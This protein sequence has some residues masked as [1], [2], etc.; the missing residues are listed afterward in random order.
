MK[1]SFVIPIY[2]HFRLINDLLIEINR[3][4]KPDEIIVVDDCST[5][6]ETHDGLSWWEQNAD[7]KVIRPIENLGFLKASNYGVSK[8]TGDIICL[9]SSDVKIED[10]L[11]K[12]VKEMIEIDPKVLIGGIV[13]KD[14]TGWNEFT[15]PDGTKKIFPYAEGWLLC[16][17]KE[18]WMDWGGFDERF[19][20]NDFEDVD[21]STTAIGKGYALIS[22][23]NPKIHHLGGQTIGY[24]DERRLLTQRNREK[25]QEKWV[26]GK[27]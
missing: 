19:C 5:D 12:L 1:V 10:D 24:T 2:N 3:N 11:V 27:N 25:F 17:T 16:F 21:F 9:I 8:A 23:G 7:V 15:L 26:N 13:Y 6:K 18:A 4:T 14:S 20:P 22:I